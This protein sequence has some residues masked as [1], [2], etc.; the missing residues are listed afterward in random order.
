MAT[1]RAMPHPIR[2]PTAAPPQVSAEASTRNCQRISLRVAPIALAAV[3]VVGLIRAVAVAWGVTPVRSVAMEPVVAV[4]SAVSFPPGSVTRLLTSFERVITLEHR[5][6]SLEFEQV[7][8]KFQQT[9]SRVWHGDAENYPLAVFIRT[10][11][12]PESDGWPDLV[13]E[14]RSGASS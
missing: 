5:E 12:D 11:P 3:S 14:L 4:A 8:D 9:F 1:I 13:F 2:S 6:E 10:R 7:A